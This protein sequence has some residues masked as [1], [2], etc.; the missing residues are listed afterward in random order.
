MMNLRRLIIHIGMDKTGSTAI[1]HVLNDNP[2]ALGRCGYRYIEA[3]RD[4]ELNHQ[5]LTTS[6]EETIDR[7]REIAEE[8]KQCTETGIVSFE[9][10][11]HYTENHW[12]C[13]LDMISPH[14]ITIVFYIRR[15][16]EMICSGIAQRVKMRW[17]N[18]AF[19]EYTETNFAEMACGYHDKLD[20]LARVFG[21][22]RIHLR[23]YEDSQLINSD[24]VTDFF[25]TIGIN[26]SNATIRDGFKESSQ[27]ANPTID[28]ETI[29]VLDH[30]DKLGVDPETRFNAVQLLR[31]VSRSDRSTL[32]PDSITQAIEDTYSR[33]NRLVAECWFYR[34]TLFYDPP[35]FRY[36]QP[37]PVR[38]SELFKLLEDNFIYCHESS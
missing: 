25:T 6:A 16:S 17:G 21:H 18:L 2:L 14:P 10:L 28:V 34:D 33:D 20:M 12:N 37:D 19:F 15:Q 9:G 24:V 31:P 38:V 13:I 22:D 27:I 3:G 32:V 1:Q 23:V 5:P 8:F 30:L 29:F 11:Y 4:E 7:W 35:K 36:R 26:L